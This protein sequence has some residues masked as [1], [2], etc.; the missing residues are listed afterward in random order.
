MTLLRFDLP[1]KLSEVQGLDVPVEV[2]DSKMTLLHETV[3]SRPVNVPAG[4]HYVITARFPSHTITDVVKAEG[5]DMQVK[6]GAEEKEE[7]AAPPP[8]P[9]ATLYFASARALSAVAPPPLPKMKKRRGARAATE[10]VLP[11]ATMRFFAGNVLDS[12]SH[13]IPL[14]PETRNKSSVVSELFA[15]PSNECRFL[16][17]VHA[18]LPP[19]NIALPISGQ[20][21]CSIVV[22]R[23]TT[24]YWIEVFPLHQQAKLLLGYAQNQLVQSEASMAKRL[25]FEKVDDPI[26]ATIG[27]YSLLRVAQLKIDSQIGGWLENLMTM[28]GWL[29]DGAAV[30]AE[31]LARWG[32]HND[33]LK[34]FEEVTSRGLPLFSDGIRYTYDRLRYYADETNEVPGAKKANEALA[35]IKPFVRFIDFTK[36]VTTFL[37][38]DPNHPGPSDPLTDVQGMNVGP[39][40]A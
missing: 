13:P 28:F 35:R 33:A 30:R 34:A 7:D 27:A 5:A 39:L 16:Q 19:V 8:E 3:A 24:R 26:A 10:S 12:G 38:V 20:R 6:L 29:P 4:A 22:R 32:K 36:P 25:I 15:P 11:V 9:E 2:R 18:N 40:F 31:H 37:G 21:G 1:L 17:C 14:T 23:E